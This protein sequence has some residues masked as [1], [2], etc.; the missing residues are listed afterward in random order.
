[1]Q[2][3]NIVQLHRTVLRSGAEKTLVTLAFVLGVVT[4]PGYASEDGSPALSLA[5]LDPDRSN[6]IGSTDWRN[7][8]DRESAVKHQAHADVANESERVFY[9]TLDELTP[10]DHAMVELGQISEFVRHAYPEAPGNNVAEK[11]I[12][13]L[14]QEASIAEQHG[15]ENQEPQEETKPSVD[16]RIFYGG[17]HP[18]SNCDGMI[19]KASVNQGGEE[20]DAP[21]GPIYPN[22]PWTPHACSG[23]KSVPAASVAESQDFAPPAQEGQER[24]PGTPSEIVG[25]NTGEPQQTAEGTDTPN[26]ASEAAGV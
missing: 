15:L 23:V 24:I 20:F 12:Y 5:Y 16:D 9:T 6:L 17:P 7:A 19:V 18:C 26:Q 4:E 14:E 3:G 8:F 11:V 2:Q 21:E 10:G 22:T 13:L 25:E 1:V